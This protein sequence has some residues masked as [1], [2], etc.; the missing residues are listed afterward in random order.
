MYRK[1][2]HVFLLLQLDFPL[3]PGT[4]SG[5]IHVASMVGRS[6]IAQQTKLHW[7]PTLDIPSISLPLVNDEFK[8]FPV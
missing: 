2:V 6:P 5:H 3:F 4:V 7:M 1:C 8:F